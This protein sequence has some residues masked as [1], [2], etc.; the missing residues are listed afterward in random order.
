MQRR[1]LTLA[2]LCAIQHAASAE[3]TADLGSL[4][5]TAPA[6]EEPLTVV[7]DPKAPRQP[8]PAH[9]G[10]DYL[11]TIPG[12]SVIRKGGVD[13]DP[14]L[15][16]MAGSRLN[17]LQ[18]GELI[19]GGCGGRMDPPTAY[20]YPESFDKVT[21]IKGPQSVRHGPVGS[22]GTV[23]FE[24]E[25][26]RYAEPGWKGYG[27]ALFGS[28]GRN[29]Q[30]IGA[31]GGA[32]KFYLRGDA[33]RSQMDDYKDGSNNLVH[34]EYKRWSTHAAVGWTPD[35]DT[36]LELSAARSDGKA[37][38]ADRGM[39]GSKFDRE[40][41]G[42]KFEK[43]NLSE[44]VEK[45]EA[46]AY[47]NS[48]DHVMD[49]YS[50]RTKTAPMY[51][52]NNPDRKTTGL[53]LASTLRFGEDWRSTL[54]LDQQSNKHT[55]RS[56]SGMMEPNYKALSRTED[57]RF[58]QWGLFGDLEYLLGERNRLLAGLRADRWKAEDHRS[59]S[60]TAGQERSKTLYSG[61]V[62]EEHDFSERTVGYIGLGHSERFPD[63]WELISQDK[64]S[65]ATTSA[66]N[67]R[68][69]KLT[70]IDLGLISG[71]GPWHLSLAG[72]IN[73]IDDY[74]LIDTQYP[75]K[76]GTT[77]VR[78]VDARSWGG[79]AGVIWTRRGWKL[80]GTLAYVHGS[81]R[82]DG[83]ALAQLPPLELRLGAE[84]S[85]GVWSVGGLMRAVDKQSRVDIGA[86]NI[87]GQ[88]IGPTSGFTVFSLNGAW[89]PN[90]RV[91]ISAGVD[92]LFNKLYAEHI[93]RSGSAV[94]GYTQTLRIN[95]PGRTYW[96]KANVKM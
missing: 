13:G 25:P 41:W 85:T 40:N 90:P 15:R 31:S 46:Q 68:S 20:I 49:N 56:A 47:Y 9:D 19:L 93:S 86:G 77:L 64:Q 67:T 54:G 17:I 87:V 24:R 60:A 92:N 63:Y 22:A 38:Y 37:A 33:T 66:F 5:I 48:I 30:A 16:G 1:I 58:S 89:K 55:L 76:V 65:E 73:R 4:I 61:Y 72:F 91:Q 8:L 10:A 62:R 45:I 2:V 81:N 6:M 71:Q 3:E 52:V 35:A 74:I 32:E 69:E 94:A 70:Q 27:S 28:F 36:T 79:E 44:V 82:T 34:S 23:L 84:Y 75:G 50:L 53:R 14:M 29:D 95:E 80:D 26:I 12:F 42:L 39:D 83:T 88:D 78:N 11:K 18:D 51:M 59:S 21:V 57:A 43:R 7:T 96:L